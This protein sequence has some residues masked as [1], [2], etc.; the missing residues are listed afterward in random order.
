MHS[1]LV[2]LAAMVGTILYG[3]LLAWNWGWWED[4][5]EARQARLDKRKE[6]CDSPPR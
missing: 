1:F 6:V 4:R 5:W 2:V 3:W